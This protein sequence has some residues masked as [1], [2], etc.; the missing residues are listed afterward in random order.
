MLCTIYKKRKWKGSALFKKEVRKENERRN[1]KGI[2]S[3]LFYFTK[4]IK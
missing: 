3:F 2:N 1:K 4:G